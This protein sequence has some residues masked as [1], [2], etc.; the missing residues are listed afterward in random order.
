MS[1][2]VL[3]EKLS[4]EIAS[5]NPD[6][7]AGWLFLGPSV[8]YPGAFYVDALDPGFIFDFEAIIGQYRILWPKDFD[9]FKHHAMALK[10]EIAFL[11]DPESLFEAVRALDEPPPISLVSELPGTVNGFLPWQVRGFNKLL[12]PDDLRG[13]LCFWDTGT[14]K[15]AFVAAGI[16]WHRL[17]HSYDYALVVVKSNNKRDMQRKLFKLGSIES[18]IL[19]GRPERRRKIYEDLNASEEPQVVITNYEKFRDDQVPIGDL[20]EDHRALIFWD[21]MP[22]RLSNRDTQLYNAIRDVL[23][24]PP[25]NKKG[26]VYAYGAVKWELKRPSWL[27]QYE[28]TATPVEKDPG[29]AF[30]CVR[31]IDPDVLGSAYK[32][33]KEFVLY[34]NHFS[35]KPE[36]WHHVEKI[37]HKIEPITHRVD[38]THPEVAKYFPKLVQETVYIDW[39]ERHRALYDGLELQAKF[40]LEQE[41]D[42]SILGLI[43]VMQMACDAP[44]ML[45]ASAE[46]REQFISIIESESEQALGKRGSEL[47]FIFLEGIRGRLSNDGHT[48]L[49]R[50]REDLTERHVDDKVLLFSTWSDYIFPIFETKLAEWGVSYE[51]F[52]GTDTQRQAAKDRFRSDPATRV[53]VSSDAGS[54]SVDLPEASLVVN[55]NLPWLY[56]RM[57]QRIHRA[58]RADS[59]H[60][61]L[62]VYNYVMDNSVEMRRLEL[63]EERKGYHN[64]I[65]G[66]QTGYSQADLMNI[67]FGGEMV[68]GV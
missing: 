30:S 58:S 20:L 41:G 59:Q 14:G 56:S 1:Y 48:K 22:T 35:K 15:T 23:Y 25:V 61:T 66:G 13:G 27:R 51:I 50:L 65:V 4:E 54:D 5:Q 29:G 40:L 34:R 43:Q 12:R 52:R 44:E 36:R 38:K 60:D 16:N 9:S 18:I 49:D 2:R 46:N 55:Y 39:A 42:T 3:D 6:D 57:Y 64:A 17:A 11:E 53:L 68:G 7:Q 10:Y 31:L 47:A 33:E 37:A 32:F 62:F 28:L 19:D 63:I 8:E 21:E 24:R 45:E 26:K 67:L